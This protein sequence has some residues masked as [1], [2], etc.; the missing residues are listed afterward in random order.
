MVGIALLTSVSYPFPSLLFWYALPLNQ[1]N[2]KQLY[3]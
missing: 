1:V 2:T 3:P